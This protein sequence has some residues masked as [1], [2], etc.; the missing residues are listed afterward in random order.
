MHTLLL[1]KVCCWHDGGSRWRSCS[2]TRV[3]SLVCNKSQYRDPSPGWHYSALGR[4][5]E[6][7]K[8]GDTTSSIISLI[9]SHHPE[10]TTVAAA[11]SAQRTYTQQREREERWKPIRDFRALVGTGKGHR[12]CHLLI[13]SRQEQVSRVSH[14]RINKS[15]TTRRKTCLSLLQS[16]YEWVRPRDWCS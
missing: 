1:W 16:M 12:K 13:C 8:W 10:P 6:E 2:E 5:N 9:S 15:F 14:G 4:K 11:D 7:W 3:L